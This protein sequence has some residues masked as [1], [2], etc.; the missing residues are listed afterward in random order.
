MN[1]KAER[2]FGGISGFQPKRTRLTPLVGRGL[3]QANHTLLKSEV[4]RA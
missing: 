4:L 3:Y 2:L 1:G